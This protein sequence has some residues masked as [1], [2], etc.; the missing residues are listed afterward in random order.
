[1]LRPNTVLFG[2]TSIP[3]ALRA[4]RH[5][6]LIAR[7]FLDGHS[8]DL[9]GCAHSLLPPAWVTPAASKGMSPFPWENHGN[10]FRAL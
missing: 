6:S 1:M 7:P 4:T 5:S 9:L 10:I 8:P 3:D 2:T